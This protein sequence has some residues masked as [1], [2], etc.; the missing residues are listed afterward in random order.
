MRTLAIGPVT[1]SSNAR[2]SECRRLVSSVVLYWWTASICG[3]WAFSR[4][5]ERANLVSAPSVKAI[6]AACGQR[7][8]A[9]EAMLRAAIS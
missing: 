4:R 2:G 3:E 6:A 8:E 5:S 9:V 7:R 1:R